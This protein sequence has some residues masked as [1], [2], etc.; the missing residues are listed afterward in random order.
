MIREIE[1]VT[2][3][4]Y[5]PF[6]LDIHY[7]GRSPSVSYAYG[8]YINNNLEGIVSYG[9]PPSSTLRRGVA[10]DKYIPDILELNRLVLQSNNKNDS[11]WLIG[12]SLKLLPRNKIVVSYADTSQDHVGYVYQATNFIY[13]GLSAKRT[14]WKVRGK[15][16]L[17]SQSIIDEFR[18]QPNRSK[19]LREKYGDDF[20]TID[21]PRKHRY[22]F[23]I[24]S[25][26]YRKEVMKNLKYS[27]KNYPKGVDKQLGS[28]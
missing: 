6:M 20:Y 15:E 3:E 11:S 4:E 7:A 16:H 24:G 21:R 19:C 17:H 13:T 23:I 27:I 25:K 1:L 18:G 22:I 12:N 5:L 28:C 26:T 10:G 8:L 2:R 9:T 14:D